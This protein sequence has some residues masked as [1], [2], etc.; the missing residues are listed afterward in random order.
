MAESNGAGPCTVPWHESRPSPS[1]SVNSIVSVHHRRLKSLNP[2]ILLSFVSQR[3]RGPCASLHSRPMFGKELVQVSPFS[4]PVAPASWTP[5]ATRVHSTSDGSCPP[6]ELP[7]PSL[8]FGLNVNDPRTGLHATER[9]KCASTASGRVSSLWRDSPRSDIPG[10]PTAMALKTIDP[11]QTP[12]VEDSACDKASTK[13]PKRIKKHRS[14]LEHDQGRLDKPTIPPL[15]QSPEGRSGG[16]AIGF[17]NPEPPIAPPAVET[18]PNQTLVTTS[19]TTRK[20]TSKPRSGNQNTIL[21]G[22]VTKPKTVS[23]ES[24]RSCKEGAR[25]SRIVSEHFD[26]KVNVH[27][28]VAQKPCKG[29]HGEKCSTKGPDKHEPLFLER[30]PARRTDWTPPKAHRKNQDDPE[31]ASPAAESI[32]NEDDQGH[33]KQQFPEL[34]GNFSYVVKATGSTATSPEKSPRS[35]SGEPFSKRRRLEVCPT[36]F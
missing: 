12:G 16:A 14:A 26:Q 27:S 25:E 9:P 7:S 18:L 8:M 19:A 11:S 13:P 29:S 5:R 20:R 24:K 35:A 36:V 2:P 4:S 10:R 17:E 6:L 21:K 31:I 34:V 3:L 22:R 30:A 28:K 15:D 32:E 33:A 23:D 1:R